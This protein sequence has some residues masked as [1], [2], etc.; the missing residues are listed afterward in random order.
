MWVLAS[1][2]CTGIPLSTPS[3]S[4]PTQPPGVGEVRARAITCSSDIP[5][6]AEAKVGDWIL[7]NS[8]LRLTIRGTLNRL[9]QLE[10]GGGT[11]IDAALWD[12]EDALVELFPHIKGGWP[13]QVEISVE[14]EAI[15]LHAQDGSARRW[16]YRL[17]PDSTALEFEGATGF[18]L[19]PPAGSERHGDFVRSPAGLTIAGPETPTDEGGWLHWSGDEIY[20]GALSDVAEDVYGDTTVA[21]GFTDGDA[22]EVY[23]GERLIFEGPVSGGEFE[24]STPRQSQLRAIKSGHAPSP[25][26]DPAQAMTLQVGE[27]GFITL[28]VFDE[29]GLP[30]PATLHWQDKRYPSPAQTTTIGVGPGLGFGVVDAGPEYRPFEIDALALSGTMILDV[31]LERTCAAAALV[32]IGTS[33]FPDPTERRLTDVLLL[34][35]AA[36]GV[37]YAILTATD[38]V[39]QVSVTPSDPHKIPVSAASQSGGPHGAP[40]AWP[41]S[42]NS[43]MAAHGAVN[44]S[45]LSPV[46]LLALMSKAGRRKT[47]V[48]TPWIEAAGPASGWDPLPHF[49]HIDGPQDGAAVARVL[50]QWVPFALVGDRSWVDTEGRTKVDIERAMFEAKTTASSGPQL[51]FFVD[52]QQP[53]SALEYADGRTASIDIANPGDVTDV[54][55]LGP[56]GMFIAQ[57]AVDDLPAETEVSHRGWVLA[58]A[59]GDS[60]WAMTSPIWLSRP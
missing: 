40:I 30:L 23:L 52:G 10:G 46:D 60:S 22:V 7:E 18:T 25:E 27:P 19:V 38:E 8:R 33:A 57:W 55:L 50:D 54:Y 45:A 34:A 39:A 48:D 53:G 17:S 29:A 42:P 49:L 21:T 9:T 15:A 58:V 12:G 41:W 36:E 51:Q 47:V 6:N 35:L 28:S 43:K 3:A 1:L 37:D 26:V 13:E 24:F 4:C 14:D 56:G 11:I 5:K 31:V 2:G 32:D 16:W 59:E 20:L 44:W